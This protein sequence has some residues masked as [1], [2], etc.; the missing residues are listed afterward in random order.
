MLSPPYITL[1][2]LWI[3]FALIHSGMVSGIVLRGAEKI[4]GKRYPYY[5]AI[6]SLFVLVAFA[7]LMHYHFAAI[8]TI[9]WRP[10]WIEQIIA[11]IFILSG[12]IVMIIFLWKHL[13]EISG[14]AIV[15]GIDKPLALH[16]TCLHAYSRH[17]MYM[18]AMVFIWGVFLGYPYMNNLVSAVC[19]TLYSF[20]AIWLTQKR[21]LALYGEAYK[22]Y[23]KRVGLI[24]FSRDRVPI[25]S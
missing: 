11:A 23:T 5:R 8:D 12:F 4:M 19:L 25:Q 10:H 3:I 2:I 17:P 22:Q 6:H 1:I 20:V 18:G 21:S 15:F 9:L 24:S 7:F 16:D 13:I 14:L